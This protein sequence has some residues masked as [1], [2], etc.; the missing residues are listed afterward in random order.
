[1][2]HNS[3]E[4][5]QEIPFTEKVRR[6]LWGTD[7]PPGLKD[8][9]GGPS[10]FERAAARRQEAQRKAS[11]TV[12]EARLATTVSEEREP[13][14]AQIAPRPAGDLS[15]AE[16]QDRGYEP[17]ETWD[18]LEWVGEVADDYKTV[19]QSEAD[20]YTPYAMRLSPS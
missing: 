6:K 13:S 4:E 3:T 8:P 5:K 9:Y 7:N 17:A 14:G 15:Q 11:S 18:G 1:M 12:P 2:R 10:M 19:K 20:A 16:L